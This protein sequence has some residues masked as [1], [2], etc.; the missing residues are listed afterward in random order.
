MAFCHWRMTLC[1]TLG[2]SG[3][4]RVKIFEKKYIEICLKSIILINFAKSII[5]SYE[6]M[7]N[8]S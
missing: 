4:G 3:K 6:E 7:R 5:I 8:L 2:A 1:S